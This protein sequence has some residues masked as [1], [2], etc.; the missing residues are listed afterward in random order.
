MCLRFRTCFISLPELR[1]SL[2]VAITNAQRGSGSGTSYTFRFAVLKSH[3]FVIRGRPGRWIFMLIWLRIH[4][5][6][7]LRVVCVPQ[8][9]LLKISFLF[10]ASFHTS[11]ALFSAFGHSL[12]VHH[13]PAASSLM[14]NL[15]RVVCVLLLPEPSFSFRPD[16]MRF[17]QYY[18]SQGNYTVYPIAG[19]ALWQKLLPSCMSASDTQLVE[20]LSLVKAPSSPL[21]DFSNVS[22]SIWMLV[23]FL[24]LKI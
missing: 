12:P 2:A 8:F 21:H 6:V 23:F 24:Y 18:P 11:L 5:T 20:P 14:L 17:R 7:R 1:E 10:R 19:P 9:A 13:F 16:A 22:F 3:C 4:P 15:M